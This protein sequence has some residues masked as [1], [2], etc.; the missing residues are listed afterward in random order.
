MNQGTCVNRVGSYMCECLPGFLG[1]RCEENINECDS[2][3][4]HQGATCVD[5][6]DSYVCK[7]VH[8]FTGKQGIIACVVLGSCI[9]HVV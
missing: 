2:D 8:G 1:N 3:P 9:T 4:C 7:C 6:V 5:G